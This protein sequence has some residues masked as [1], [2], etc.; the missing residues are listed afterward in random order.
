MKRALVAVAVSVGLLSCGV[1]AGESDSTPP[2][3]ESGLFI[4]PSYSW[5]DLNVNYLDWSGGTVR[6]TSHTKKDF[7]YVEFEGGIGWE[8][9]EL[10]FFTDLENPGEGFDSSKAPDDSRW[11]IKPILDIRIPGLPESIDG[12]KIH[13][14]DYYLYSDS[15]IVNNLVVGLAYKFS[16]EN[17]LFK[18]FVGLHYMHDSFNSTCHDGYMG[19]WVANYDFSI[20]D[21]RFSLSNWHEFEWDRKDGTYEGGDGED[22]G[23]N[24]AMALWWHM[25]DSVTAGL[26]YRYAYHKLGSESYQNGVI[27]TLKY[28]F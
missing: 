25:N 26:Q 4:S 11:V 22:W 2:K 19:G 20:L 9:G 12:L 15:F 27:Y 24:G 1:S 10:Y 8:W 18:P 21:N 14:Q 16:G 23:V 7:P 5:F 13:I 6:R 17:Y 28:N 3:E